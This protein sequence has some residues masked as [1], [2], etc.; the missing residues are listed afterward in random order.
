M[1]RKMAL[2]ESPEEAIRRKTLPGASPGESVRRKTSPGAPPGEKVR[3]SVSPGRSRPS[4]L[5]AFR[6]F[7]EMLRP[8]ARVRSSAR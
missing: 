7:V 4:W 3:R 2:G 6:C 5:A 1:S 8:F